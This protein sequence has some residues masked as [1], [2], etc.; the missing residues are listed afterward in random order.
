MIAETTRNSIEGVT[1]NLFVN[2]NLYVKA[3]KE[4]YG[5]HNYAPLLVEGF[6]KTIPNQTYDEFEEELVLVIYELLQ[7]RGNR[8]RK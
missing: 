7:V 8:R 1:L 2:A 4:Y 3:L 5:G 6:T